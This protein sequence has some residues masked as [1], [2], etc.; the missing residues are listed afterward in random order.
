MI[1]RLRHMIG[2]PGEATS[3]DGKVWYRAVPLP[4]YDGLIERFRNAWKIITGE[5]YAIYWPE[6]GELEHALN[7]DPASARKSR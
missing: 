1:F 6:P 3:K 7:F 4:F 2:G 5:A